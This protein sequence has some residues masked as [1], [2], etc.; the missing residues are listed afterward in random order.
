MKKATPLFLIISILINILL[1]YVFVIKGDTAQTENDVRTTI[2][3]S[4]AN[5][6]FVLDEMRDFLESIQKINQGILE[7]NASLVIE[8]GEKSGGSV[9]AHAPKG[10]LSA[11]P[12]G[13]KQLGF[14]THDIFDEIAKTANKDFSPKQSQEQ[15][16]KL[17]NNCIAC[18]RSYKLGVN[19]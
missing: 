2:L 3:V 4:Q 16:N 13:F 18:H 14:A 12:I 6:D 7:N 1:I 9:I 15:L 10:L 19:E 8:A 11:L 17:L 5:E